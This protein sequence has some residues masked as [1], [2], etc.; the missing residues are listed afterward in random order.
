MGAK[1]G[2]QS[3]SKEDLEQQEEMEVDKAD[4]SE[5]DDDSNEEDGATVEGTSAGQAN[6]AARREALS[7]LHEDIGHQLGSTDEHL[8]LDLEPEKAL[9]DKYARILNLNEE[10]ESEN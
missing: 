2:R 3:T 1:D 6:R 8:N 5:E 7:R 9:I 4:G 10:E